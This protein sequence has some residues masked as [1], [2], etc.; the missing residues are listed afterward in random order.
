MCF[1]MMVPC[2]MLRCMLV[3]VWVRIQALNMIL[4]RLRCKTQWWEANLRVGRPWVPNIFPRTYLNFKPISLVV[5]SMVLPQMDAM[6]MV[7]RSLQKLGGD[8]FVGDNDFNSYVSYFLSLIRTI[9]ILVCT[10]ITWFLLPLNLGWWWVE[11]GRLHSG[12]N[13]S[14]FISPTHNRCHRL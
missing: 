2:C 4:L 12:P 13:H 1:G 5:R 10:H 8:S 9:S 11:D 3:C 6:F 14:K 7:P